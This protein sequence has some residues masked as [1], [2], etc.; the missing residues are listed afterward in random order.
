M[1]GLLTYAE[2]QGISYTKDEF[3]CSK[4]LQNLATCPGRQPSGGGGMSKLGKTFR[5]LGIA[6]VALV[7][8]SSC[9]PNNVARQ[10]LLLP[11]SW[12]N[13]HK[14]RATTNLYRAGTQ[15]M[16]INFLGGS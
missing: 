3:G 4:I 1:D 10:V 9:S 12:A 7:S 14:L 5:F 11:V 15:K 13:M 16:P 8:R 2:E 6:V